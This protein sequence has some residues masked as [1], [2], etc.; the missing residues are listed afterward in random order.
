MTVVL[1]EANSSVA[2]LAYIGSASVSELFISSGGSLGGTI[3][4]GELMKMSE[5]I[6]VP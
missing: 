3:N 5:C 4:F 6:S 1:N 2:G